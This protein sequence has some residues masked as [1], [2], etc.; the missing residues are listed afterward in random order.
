MADRIRI[1]RDTAAGWISKDP[2][3]GLGELGIES[4]TLR[5][6]V[7]DGATIWSG[8]L[9]VGQKSPTL[10]ADYTT[11]QLSS[12]PAASNP[13]SR[14]FVNDIGAAGQPAYSDGVNWRRDDNNLII[15]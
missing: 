5:I 2:I 7:G 15:V 8:L 3:L 9:Y 12:L 1:R 10:E 4:D 6:K 14:I 11:A 13:F